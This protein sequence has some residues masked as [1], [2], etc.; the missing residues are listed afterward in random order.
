MKASLLILDEIRLNFSSGGLF[1]LNLTLAFIMF[2][3]A[4]EIKPNQ[5]KEILKHPKAV[6]VGFLSQFVI[7]PALTFILIFFFR[8]WITTSV[9]L[10]MVLVAACPGGNVSNLISVL[11]KGNAAL[12]VSLTAI[13]TLSSVIFTPLNF[14]FWGGLFTK[15]SPL[16]VPIEIPF[17]G[18]FQTVFMLLGIPLIIG[19]LFSWKFPHLTNRIIKPIK[20]I[21]VIIFIGFIVVAFGNNIDY[22]LKYIKYI[23]LLVLIHNALALGS[24]YL[25]GTIAGIRGQNRRTITIETGI[26]NSGL[27]L[28]LIFN[29]GIFPPELQ[30]G[31][32]AFV[33]A[34]WGIW[35]IFSGLSI[36][37]FWSRKTVTQI[38]IVPQFNSK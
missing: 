35:H 32:M 29:P 37:A 31:G 20:T 12:S 26:Q 2:G 5:F 18:M 14:A 25:F 13:A 28:I 24:G 33:A 4:L 11:A 3:I 27:A 21:S 17:W 23:F 7:L 19:M 22:F 9:A 16:L 34:W 38:D 1:I 10:G 6:I 30:T 15:T 8:N 36:A